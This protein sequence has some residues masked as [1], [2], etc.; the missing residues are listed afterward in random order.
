MSARLSTR[1]PLGSFTAKLSIWTHFSFLLTIPANRPA[2][3]VGNCVHTFRVETCVHEYVVDSRQ[4][5]VEQIVFIAAPWFRC[6]VSK[7]RLC[8]DAK[9]EVAEIIMEV[10]VAA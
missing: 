10:P 6:Q 5:H 2:T 4:K 3:L 7:F 9:G 8:T 1:L